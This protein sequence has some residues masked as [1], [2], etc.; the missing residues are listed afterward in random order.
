MT[1]SLRTAAPEAPRQRLRQRGVISLIEMAILLGSLAALVI[2]LTYKSSDYFSKN[3]ALNAEALLQMADHQL[4]Q[5]AVANGRLPCPDLNADGYADDD[6]S[7]NCNSQQKGYLPYKTLGM[8]DKNY[9]YGEVPILYGVYSAGAVSFT[10][11]A[12]SFFPTYQDKSNNPVQVNNPRGVFDFCA[13]LSQLKQLSSP[14]AAGLGVTDGTVQFNAVYALAQAGQGDL[15]AAA[16]GW[17]GGPTINAQYDGRNATSANWFELP[18]AS[19][20]SRYD[21]RT[22]FRAAPDL[23]DFFRCDAMNS[24]ISVMTEAVTLQKETE[25]FAD[26]NSGGPE[27]RGRHADEYLVQQHSGR[28]CRAD[29]VLH[30][31]LHLRRHPV[32]ALHQCCVR[33]ALHHPWCQ[34]HHQQLDSEGNCE[35]KSP[36]A[37]QRGFTFLEMAMSLFSVGFLL[38]A[39]PR[40]LT[41]G[42]TVVAS[43][44]GAVPIE[45]AE[46]VLNGFVLANSRLPC[47]AT[48]PF[49]GVENCAL[50]KGF[51]PYKTLKMPRPAV[52]SD[53]H[54]IAY[55]VLTDDANNNHLAK[56]TAKFTPQY[57]DSND[58]YWLTPGTLTSTQLNGMDFCVKL[59]NAA[60]RAAQAGL[61]GIQ[62]VNGNGGVNVAWA[63]I[64]PGQNNADGSSSGSYPEFDGNNDPTSGT[65]WFE[66]P[67][68][69][70]SGNYDDVVRVGTLTQMYGELHCADLTATLS[71]AAREADYAN[72]HWRVRKFLYDFRSYE[73]DVRNQKLTQ[74]NNFKLLAIFDVSMTVALG[75]LDLGI[76]LAGASGAAAIAASAVSA[77]TSIS[78]SAYGL[79]DAIQGVSDASNEVTEGTNR[80]NDAAIAVSDAAAFR[81][82]RRDALVLVDQRGAF[83]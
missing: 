49:S 78:M 3:Q 5:Y 39:V 29:K 72:D 67:G 61:T 17:S 27:L 53:G 16:T 22:F 48:T 71:A 31:R 26:A 82:S 37:R 38:A 76:A 51:L 11:R 10:S 69:A 80:K 18:Q 13:T 4:R 73:L 33:R 77:V 6:V 8:T 42:Q 50:S 1:P 83:Q 57:L 70:L 21:D 30:P 68:K 36:R 56:L 25:D 24:S 74:A 9:V 58:N 45:A 7:G 40:V 54:P 32:R 12:Q 75:V 81:T 34:H 20:T 63:L 2:A 46:L 28:L 15:D 14:A 35:M 65:H 79:A 23:Y 66:S 60:G 52:N 41:Q 19:V 44:P 64:D 62:D 47:P 43:A 55:A 59:R